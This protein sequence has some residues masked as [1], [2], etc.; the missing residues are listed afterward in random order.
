MTK[1]HLLLTFD[2]E[3]YLGDRS[4]TPQDCLIAPTRHLLRI[5]ARHPLKMIFFVDTLYLL[6]LRKQ[7]ATDAKC[8]EDLELVSGQL[9]ELVEAGH[10]LFPHLHA[11]WLDAE[12]R[13]GVNEWL[14]N[15]ARYYRLHA[16][17]Q[18]L[19]RQLF[20]ESMT[21]LEKIVRSAGA[22]YPIDAYRAGGWSIQ[23]F[24][25][26]APLFREFGI[27]HEF[28]VA[29]RRWS[30]TRAHWFDFTA[31]EQA[32]GP[33]PFSGDVVKPD[34]EGDFIEFPISFVET[35]KWSRRLDMLLRRTVYKKFLRP[36]GKGGILHAESLPHDPA[37]HQDLFYLQLASVENFRAPFMPEYKRFIE[38][39]D[40]LHFISHPKLLSH[41][42]LFWLDRILDDLYDRHEVESDFRMMVD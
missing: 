11:H 3:L 29:A 14:L 23:P 36:Y 32:S 26:F 28:S 40:Y 41:E 8:G 15:D 37:R 10:Y 35:G 17:D 18:D 20:G 16:V 21:L 31:I 42:N 24:D 27:R 33:Y 12:Y 13:P 2:Y 6:R 34:P 39:N 1:K 25:L 38:K 19:R 4:G 22:S 30:F 5:A 9:K 7:A